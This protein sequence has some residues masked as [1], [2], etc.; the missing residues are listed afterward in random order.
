VPLPGRVA[1]A[2]LI[3]ACLA[4]GGP[5]HAQ[6]SP[7]ELSG[8]IEAAYRRLEVVIEQ[9]NDLREDLAATRSRTAALERRTRPLLRDLDRRRDR[10][11]EFAAAAYRTGGVGRAAIL[12]QAGSSRDVVDRLLFLGYLARQQ[13]HEIDG[14]LGAE[15]SYQEIRDDL[16]GL[17]ARQQAQQ[18]ALTVR[19]TQIKKEI[20]KLEQLRDRAYAVGWRPDTDRRMPRLPPGEASGVVRFAYAQIGKQYRFAADGPDAYDC[21][22]LVAAAYRSKGVQLPHN[23]R[24]QLRS[25]T[26]I[27]RS[28][29]RPGDLVFYYGDVHHVAVYAGGGRIIHAPRYGEPVRMD[30]IDRM[31][32][33]SYGR[34]GR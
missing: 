26:P 23:S 1:A 7:G 10:V 14:L 33:H 30:P 16:H 17:A 18:R 6:P 25:V 3:V 31:P 12:L 21:S 13:Q 29:L 27:S 32:V 5:A 20:V 24:G 22:G 4:P 2:V 34:V 9:Y 28:Q 19:R 15:R 11:G 8:R